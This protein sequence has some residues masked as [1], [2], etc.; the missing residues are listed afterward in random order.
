M[1]SF[2]VNLMNDQYKDRQ[3]TIQGELI[4]EYSLQ[5]RQAEAKIEELHNVIKQLLNESEEGV[6]I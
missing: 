3:I 5:L 4:R 6:E 2:G 1:T